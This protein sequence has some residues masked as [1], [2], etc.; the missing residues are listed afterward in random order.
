MARLRSLWDAHG[1]VLAAR[2]VGVALPFDEFRRMLSGDLAELLPD[3]VAPA[4]MAGWRLITADGEFDDNVWDLEQ[5]QRAV[6]R[7]LVSTTRGE[8]PPAPRSS[9]VS[10]NRTP[11]TRRCANGRTRV[12][13][14]AVDGR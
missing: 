5:E 9:R 10:W 1:A 12:P 8:S 2:G 7:A 11:C 3:G 14:N 13:M 6:L 4:E